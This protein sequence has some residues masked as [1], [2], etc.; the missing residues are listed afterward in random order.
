M[1]LDLHLSPGIEGTVAS[2][3]DLGRWRRDAE[4][5]QSFPIQDRIA[6]VPMKAIIHRGTDYDT[7][8]VWASEPVADFSTGD[9]VLRRKALDGT[10]PSYGFVEESLRQGNILALA[11]SA[12]GKNIPLPGDSVRF[13]PFGDTKDALG[14]VPGLLAKAVP[15]LG[16]D[17]APFD[18]VMTD[19][20]GDG[21]AS[22]VVLRYRQPLSYASSERWMFHWPSDSGGLDVRVVPIDSATSD[23]GGRILT[24]RVPPFDYGS[25]SCPESTGCAALGAMFQVV[26]ADS[27]VTSFAVR[28]GV[29][30]VPLRGTLRYTGVDGNPDTLT[31]W[32]SEP[33][34]P[35]SGSDSWISW[36]KMVRGSQGNALQPSSATLDSSRRVAVFLVDT[37]VTPVVGDGIRINTPARGGLLDS[38][39][40]A[41][42][43]TA[44]WA[45]LVLG[46]I[47]P[48]LSISVYHP[49]R[50]SNGQAVPESEVPVQVLV[51]AGK[52]SGSEWTTVDG[53]AIPDTSRL[54]GAT[55]V[56]NGA[57]DASAYIYDNSGVYVAGVALDAAKA[58]YLAGEIHTDARGNYEVWIAWDGKSASGRRA[59]SG[60]YVMRVVADRLVGGTTYIQQK[61]MRLGWID[62]N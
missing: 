28:D 60:I 23:S 54:L 42:Q 58:A 55:I 8:L 15:I 49:V 2:S 25:T 12:T 35:A 33:V 30:P 31:A 7:L 1:V 19:P 29:E 26:G 52:N 20:D 4:P 16:T 45:P 36:G 57:T 24:F 10:L 27:A 39:G 22:Q 56:L 43:D 18:A 21:R 3:T 34:R 47:P 17:R 37:T 48:K 61:L 46:P 62:K 6:P 32:F 13:P 51:H 38:A 44:A 50:E 11:F 53:S 9:D 5:W 59:P 14:N 40:N 41:A